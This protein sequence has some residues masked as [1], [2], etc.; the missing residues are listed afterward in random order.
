MNRRDVLRAAVGLPVAAAAGAMLPEERPDGK[1]A[2]EICIE[3]MV[4]DDM[5]RILREGHAHMAEQALERAQ[6][7]RTLTLR[8]GS[9]IRLGPV[10]P[11]DRLFG[12]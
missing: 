12:V 9:Q 8:G 7:Y 2:T 5:D 6:K 4:E 1:S 10:A 3:Q 11:E